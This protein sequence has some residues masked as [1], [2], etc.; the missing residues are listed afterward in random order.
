VPGSLSMVRT[1]LHFIS[2]FIKWT[3]CVTYT[4]KST[5]YS[6]GETYKFYLQAATARM[7]H[8]FLYLWCSGQN[9]RNTS[10]F[11]R[12]RISPSSHRMGDQ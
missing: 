1:L 2:L 5:Q 6:F 3:T 4:I 7:I 11:P 12:I 9:K 8:F 10:P